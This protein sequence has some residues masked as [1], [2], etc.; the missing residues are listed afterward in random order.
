MS[1]YTLDFVKDKYYV[2]ISTLFTLTE[3]HSSM[4]ARSVR[5]ITSILLSIADSVMSL[6]TT[7]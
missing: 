5:A 4:V 7:N 6:E 3:T 1:A 2:L